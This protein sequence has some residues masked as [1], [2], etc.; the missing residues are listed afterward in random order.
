ME[1]SSELYNQLK[2]ANVEAMKAHN[3]TQREVL[4]VLLNKVMLAQIDKRSQGGELCDA[5]V[6]GV[7]QK[8]VKELAEEKDAFEK[9]NRAEKVASLAEQIEFVSSFLPKMMSEEE[10]RAEIAKLED[11][12]IP[13]VMKHFKA[14]FAG[15]C[16]MRDVQAVLKTL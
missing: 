4:S 14:N 13:S 1:I 5:D 3:T 2:K 10:I 7:L 12:S 15:K 6:V 16:D 9:A 11:K 8:A